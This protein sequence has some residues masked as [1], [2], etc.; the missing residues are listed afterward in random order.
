MRNI[1]R[2]YSLLSK[3]SAVSYEMDLAFDDMTGS[4]II[5]QM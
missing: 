4:N 1:V 3:G 5:K 2:T